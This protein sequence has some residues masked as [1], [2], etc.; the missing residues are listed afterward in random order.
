MALSE[1]NVQIL[2]GM[3]AKVR[4]GYNSKS[5]NEKEAAEAVMKQTGRESYVNYYVNS[6][7]ASP[8]TGGQH[9]F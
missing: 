9:Y 4:K 6:N 1:T 8:H 3:C 5:R 7:Q 2:I